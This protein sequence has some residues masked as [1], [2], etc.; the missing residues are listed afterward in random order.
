M[1]EHIVTSYEQELAFLDGKIGQMGGLAEQLVG[2]AFDSLASHNPGRAKATVA[3]DATIDLLHRELEEQVILMIARR[4]PV[5]ND[6]RQDYFRSE[7]GWRTGARGRLGEER[8]Q[9]CVDDLG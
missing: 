8:C 2:E 6:L 1:S 7:G 3:S 9:T 5:A 4:Q